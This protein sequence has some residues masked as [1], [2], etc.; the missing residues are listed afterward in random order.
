MAGFTFTAT[1]GDGR[2]HIGRKPSI[3]I[4]GVE[5][6]LTKCLTGVWQD[7]DKVLNKDGSNSIRFATS[8]SND[9]DDS[10]NLN[11]FL[12]RRKVVYNASGRAQ[13]LY[14]CEFHE[15]LARFIEDKIGR[16]S[17]DPTCLIGTA[18]QVGE[19]ILNEF[20]AG[21][22]LVAKE[23]PDVFFKTIKDGVEKLEAPFDPIIVIGW[24]E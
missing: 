7:G 22:T 15:E 13:I 6:T 10:I 17:N 18:K 24:K 5:F 8:L 23:V 14:D 20:F 11:K 2:F 4:N 12:N 21:K 16:D 9:P 19:R 3:L 1:S